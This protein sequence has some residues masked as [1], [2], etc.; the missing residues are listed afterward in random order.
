MASMM[1]RR[2]WSIGA[3]LVVLAAVGLGAGAGKAALPDEGGDTLQE[4]IVTAQQR[5]QRAADVPIS[6][7]SLSAADMAGLSAQRLDDIALAVPSL[8]FGDGNEQGRVGV[9]GILD[10]ARDAGYDARVGMYVD[11]VYIGRPFLIG[12]GLADIAQV[13]VLSGPQGTLFGRDSDAGAIAITTVQPSDV[14]NGQASAT[15]GNFGTWNLAARANVPLSPKASLQVSA[16]SLNSDG[17]YHNQTLDR[18]NQG[19]QDIMG[20]AQ[21]LLRPTERFDLTISADGGHDDNSSLHYAAPPSA[22]ADPYTISSYYNDRVRRAYGGA[23]ITAHYTLPDDYRLTSI[24]AYRSGSQN[25]QFNNETGP[26]PYL[27]VGQEQKSRQISQEVRLASPRTADYDY[28]AGLYYLHQENVDDGGLYGGSGLRLLPRPYS[29]YAG[30][31]VPYGGE[32]DTDTYA[33]FLNGNYRPLSWLE[34]TAGVRYTADVKA[35]RDYHETDPLGF[36]AGRIAGYSD[37]QAAGRWLPKGGINIHLDDDT[38]TYVSVSRGFKSGGWS[39]EPATPAQLATG[40]AVAPETATNVE[41]GVKSAFWGGRGRVNVSAF[42]ETFDDFQVFTSTISRVGGVVVNGLQLTNAASATSQGVELGASLI[43]VDGLRASV[44][45]TYTDAGYDSFPGGAGAN[46][47]GR[48]LSADGVQ[49]PYAPR[50]KLYMALDDS[51][52]LG[53]GWTLS[54]HLGYSRQSAENFD[55][56]VDN[57]VYGQAYAI[58]GYDLV[59]ARLGVSYQGWEVSAWGRNLGDNHYIVFTN[60]TLLTNPAVLY[61]APRTFG[62]TLKYSF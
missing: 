38:M 54:S 61:G 32:V 43:L 18:D 57:P 26:L 19:R 12:Q 37:N 31:V 59:D 29:A 22:G 58:P 56:K 52:P 34:L 42:H 6:L 44:N 1:G 13:D 7:Q 11:G 35:L 46:A 2:P 25:L 40:I 36:L 20:R 41:V 33:A 53:E 23:S 45:Y 47:R 14:F 4:V 17:Y 10:Y 49:T 48:L 30:A 39:L 8:S 3:S 24:T 60:R 9:R 5:E 28:V 15:V 55:P 27:T 21:L 51:R 50:N 16:I 62:G